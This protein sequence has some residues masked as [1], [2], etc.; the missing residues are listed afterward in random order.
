MI[1]RQGRAIDRI[2]RTTCTK[3]VIVENC[4]VI[5]GAAENAETARL[6]IIS[7]IA[8]WRSDNERMAREARA[9]ADSETP[10]R[11]HNL[12]NSVK[13]RLYFKRGERTDRLADE[14]SETTKSYYRVY[15][16]ETGGGR[17]SHIRLT[18][19]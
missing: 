19:Q 5:T 10:T 16:A 2:R 12:V 8:K 14:V 15:E 7:T 11:P 9:R 17:N 18:L 1:G 13:R 3:I 4:A 6:L